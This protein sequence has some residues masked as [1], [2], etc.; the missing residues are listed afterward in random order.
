MYYLD[1]KS[2]MPMCILIS[3]AFVPGIVLGCLAL[4]FDFDIWI[5]IFICVW[6]AVYL[7]LLIFFLIMSK[8]KKHYLVLHESEI[9]IVYLDDTAGH[10]NL[11]L[12]YENIIQFEYHRLWSLR[13]WY[14]MFFNIVF[15]QST[16]VKYHSD[17]EDK[18]IMIGYLGLRDIKS[19]A[20]KANVNLKII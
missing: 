12:P 16:Y 14:D 15:P 6:F 20:A 3:L 7:A 2:F 8:R 5:C 18:T 17:A 11:L 1:R 4:S 13:S 19:I 10:T 9:Q